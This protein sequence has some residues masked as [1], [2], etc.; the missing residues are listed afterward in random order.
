ML[1]FRM[2]LLPSQKAS[3]CL[4]AALALLPACHRDEI[5]HAIVPKVA[6]PAPAATPAPSA[7]MPGDLPPPP[8]PKGALKWILP[9]GWTDSLSG[10]GMRYATLKPSTPGKVEVSVVVLPGPAGG[11]LP[12]VNRWRGQI[13]LPPLDEGGLAAARKT[14]KS[15]AGD[16]SAYDFKSD[17]KK[18]RMIAGL[19]TRDGSTWFVKMVGDTEPVTAASA[20]FNH[21]LESLHFDE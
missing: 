14:V 20:D 16:F 4:A 17:E 18:S 13:G 21:L 7:A 19:V 10:G 5:T 2:T 1:G 3:A 6:A 12:N 8:A 15:P 11:E 9:A